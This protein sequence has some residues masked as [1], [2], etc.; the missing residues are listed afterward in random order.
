MG[1][2]ERLELDDKDI[3]FEGM[4]LFLELLKILK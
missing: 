1:Q 4:I 2:Q 3:C